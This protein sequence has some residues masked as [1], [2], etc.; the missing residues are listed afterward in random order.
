MVALC[1]ASGAGK[2]TLAAA[3]ELRG[4]RLAADDALPF[5]L[6]PE[7]P[8]GTPLPFA[9]R[10]R[11]SAAKLLE[12]DERSPP[13]DAAE[14]APLASLV[15]LEPDPNVV[16]EPLLE[17]LTEPGTIVGLLLPQLYCFSLE[18]GKED[19]VRELFALVDTVPVFRLTYQQ[20]PRVLSDT[21]DVLEG[22]LNG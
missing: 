15:V 6:T 9:L 10:L 2:S 14:A 17:E 22:L 12:R 11:P 3:M 13:R 18:N 19:L 20:S 16:G 21:C 5:G 4:H 8:S 7:G 1:G